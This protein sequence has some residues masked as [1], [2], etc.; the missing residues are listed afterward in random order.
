VE[1]SLSP[2]QTEGGLLIVS[3]IRDVSERRKAEAQLHK[4]EAR[5]RTLVEGIP[6]VTFMAALE[7]GGTERE[8][9][10]SPQVEELLGFS[11][12]EW[13]D[14]P[15]L[16]Y[17][18]LHPEDRERWHEEFVRTVAQGEAFR[19]VYRFL[20]RQGRVVWVHGE[21]K[22]V[23]DEAGR[24][25]FLQGVAF[26]ITRLKE[27][28]SELM[29]LNQTLEERVQERTEALEERAGE[30]ERSNKDLKEYTLF[31]THELKTPV[32]HINQF[33]QMLDEECRGR[34]DPEAERTLATIRDSG[35]RMESLI[36]MMLKYAKV[37]KEGKG[38]AAT[39]CAEVLAVARAHMR[40]AIEAC[41]AEVTADALPT[42]W[43]VHDEL[44]QVFEN[45]V[46]NAI[47]Y[48][49]ERPVRVHVGVE[50]RGE[51]WEFSVRDNGVGIDPIF[52]ANKMFTIF[53]R[54]HSKRKYQGSGIGLALCKKIIEYHG[55]AIRAESKVGDGSTIRFTLPAEPPA[56]DV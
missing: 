50:R 31:V 21:A 5:F 33:S 9:Y 36:E 37:G 25:L 32:S 35:R 39:D 46:G 34:L 23:R 56:A 54:G 19:S 11:Q 41:N 45:L 55:G 40:T 13:L 16:W 17:N 14:N 18:Q 20:S 28:E 47:K 43:A 29:A 10:V 51:R 24:P 44:V 53:E 15:V 2:L 12:K 6:A 7:E 3:T 26:D 27:A 38:F 52:L 1:I 42:V 49:G 30:L 4:M 48:R 8:L 22:V